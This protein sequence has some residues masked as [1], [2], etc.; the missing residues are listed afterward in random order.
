MLEAEFDTAMRTE[1]WENL[2]GGEVDLGPISWRLLLMAG[3]H[4]DRWV[5]SFGA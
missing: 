3:C 5:E 2:P 4:R 1:F